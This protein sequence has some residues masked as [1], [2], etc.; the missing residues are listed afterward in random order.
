MKYLNGY[1]KNGVCYSRDFHSKRT[2]NVYVNIISNQPL[3]CLFL[4]CFKSFKIPKFNNKIP[5]LWTLKTAF[6]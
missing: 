5:K 3:S 4:Y 2:A 6:T 1:M